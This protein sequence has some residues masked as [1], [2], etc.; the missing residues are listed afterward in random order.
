MTEIQY[1]RFVV[2]ETPYCVWDWDITE[3]N[4]EFINSIDPRYF[5][6]IAK[7]HGE[8]LEGEDQQYAAI[9]LRTAYAHSLETFFALLCATIQ[10]PDCV[11]GWLLKYR[12]KELFDLVRKIDNRRKVFS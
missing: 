4:L 1:S 9:A 11:V 2:N 12:N 7:I 10:A 5:E 8:M 6:H 3:Q